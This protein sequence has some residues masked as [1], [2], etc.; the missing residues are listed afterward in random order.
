M[1][2][3]QGLENCKSGLDKSRF[4]ETAS[5]HLSVRGVLVRRPDSISQLPRDKESQIG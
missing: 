4:F 1:G 5:S 3:G 2:V